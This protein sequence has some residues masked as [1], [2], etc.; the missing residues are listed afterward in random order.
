MPAMT[1]REF[2]DTIAVPTVEDFQTEPSQRRGYLACLAA[3]HVGDY[4]K[5]AGEPN[6]GAVHAAMEQELGAPFLALQ[7][8]A[9]ALTHTKDSPAR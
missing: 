9:N 2:V 3:Y 5:P 1:A 7:R 6:P 8:M 4:L